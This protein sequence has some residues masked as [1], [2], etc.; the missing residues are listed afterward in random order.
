MYDRNKIV[1]G[2]IINHF[3]LPT[4][5]KRVLKQEDQRN[6]ASVPPRSPEDSFF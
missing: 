5:N 4:V 3:K 6:K 2:F 1:E